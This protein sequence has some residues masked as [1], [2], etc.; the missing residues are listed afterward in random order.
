MDSGGFST[1]PDGS[2]GD[3]MFQVSN[4]AAIRLEECDAGEPLQRQF[5]LDGVLRGSAGNC[6]NGVPTNL[7]H[8]GWRAVVGSCSDA[9]VGY[10]EFNF[11]DVAFTP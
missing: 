10:F 5:S 4:A 3:K 2:P 6:V 9:T 7:S 8:D 11:G 1:P